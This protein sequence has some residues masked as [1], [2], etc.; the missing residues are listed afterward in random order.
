MGMVRGGPTVAPDWTATNP[1]GP[2]AVG[3]KVEKLADGFIFTEGSTTDAQGN[4]FFVDQ[5]N[6]RIMEWSIDGKLSTWMQPSGY[7]NGMCFDNKGNLI[8]CADEKNELWSI[9]PDKK[10]TVLVKEYN[11]KR[12]DGPND[13]WVR[14]DGGIYMTDPL[15][16]RSWWT[17][18][19]ATAQQDKRAVYYLTPD[20]KTLTRVLDDFAMP[21]GIIGTPDGKTLYVSDINARKTYSYTINAD[22]SLTDKK[23]FCQAGSD[24]M[25]IDNEGNVYF[26]GMGLTI[27][28]K[29][30]KQIEQ[31]PR[32]YCANVCFG[33]KDRQLLFICSRDVVFG[34]RMRT[35][36][37][38]PQ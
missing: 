35:R 17:D 31:I 30:G 7:A 27:F 6:N 22:G 29:T 8:A 15:Y 21:N 33:G 19:P 28:D 24:G 26:T 37:V 3:A 16:R 12:L 1:D 9:A 36:G 38:G 13:V 11:G 10:V 4:I 23:E 14:P 25:T 20:G 34:I 32:L 5:D 2:I 18:R